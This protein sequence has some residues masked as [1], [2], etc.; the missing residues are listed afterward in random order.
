MTSTTTPS[1]FALVPSLET[2]WPDVDSSFERFCLTAGIGALEQM[3]C[4]V[5]SGSP[6]HR[7]AAVQAA[8]VTAGAGPRARSAS[9][10][11]MLQ[12]IARGCVALMA[13]NY[14]CR[15]GRRHRLR[16]GLVTGP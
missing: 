9:T 11:A 8:S 1:S 12:S 14:R 6:A 13:M 7:I 2:A 3:L 4:E 5:L 15:P 10:V 16:T